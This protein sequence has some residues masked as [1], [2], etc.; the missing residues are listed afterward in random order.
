MIPR[1]LWQ[2]AKTID[3]V[4][5]INIQ[6][7]IKSW[8]ANNVSLELKFMDDTAC[9]A[10]IKENFSA[11]YYNMYCALP[12]GVMRAD[13]WRIAVL[14]I[15][16]GIYADID[17]SCKKSIDELLLHN[18]IL[19]LQEEGT[20]DHVANFFIASI[21]KHPILKQIL[22]NMLSRHQIAFDI[23]SEML[24]QNFGMDSVQRVIR[25]N[26]IKLIPAERWSKYITHECHGT[27][28]EEEH[29]Y[30]TK[31]AEKP[32]TFFTTFHKNGYELYGR[33]WINS[34]ISNVATKGPHIK[35]IIYAHDVKI[36]ETHP[37]I[38]VL[39]FCSSIPAHATWKEDFEKFGKSRFSPYVYDNAIRFSHKGFVISHALDKIK[40]GY[41]IW[42]DGDCV[43]HDYTYDNFPA[44]ILE[45]TGIACQLEEVG[46]SNHH[47]ES[48]FLAFDTSHI[49]YDQFKKMFKRNYTIDKILEMSEP[50]DGFVVYRSIKDANINFYNLNSK[51]GIGGIQSDPTLTFLHPEIKS[52]FTHNIGLTGK[53]QYSAWAE[54]KYVDKV[55]GQ[56]ACVG[57]LSA[58]QIK[59]LKLR[60]KLINIRGS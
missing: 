41:A 54:L 52:R 8:V 55:Y 29:N 9:Y 58:S 40:N 1:V 44:N 42:L 47:I 25:D 28:R 48:G 26:N 18:D 15:H 24:V 56:L 30:R 46:S 23:S 3:K 27:W 38:T 60:R 35:A 14:Y 50:Y 32:I 53:E 51:Y 19:F 5:T 49:D 12:L 17:S 33:E 11:E 2:T 7:L 45:N 57:L 20:A 6:Y 4:S 34:F 10:F 16:G 36:A 37:Q 39:D 43:M 22:E 21:P 13:F 31:Q 59:S